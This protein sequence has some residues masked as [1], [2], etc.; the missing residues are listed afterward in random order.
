VLNYTIK[1]KVWVQCA[2]SNYNLG[3]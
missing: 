3:L 1:P 2:V